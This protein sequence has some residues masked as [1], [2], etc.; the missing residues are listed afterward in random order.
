MF[1]S[2]DSDERR[3]LYR[4]SVE[5]PSNLKHEESWI[6]N[7]RGMLIYRQSFIPTEFKAV[8]CLVHGF[9]DHS[10]NLYMDLSIM[11]A[12]AGYAVV[13]IDFE[14]H[15][16]SDGLHCFIPSLKFLAD[17]L[18]QYLKCVSNQ[19][20][21]RGKKLFLYGESMGGATT[22]FTSVRPDV[23]AISG[24]ILVAPMIKI[25]DKMKPPQ[26]VIDFLIWLSKY[27]PTSPIAPVPD[28]LDKCFKRREI[29]LR[30]RSDPLAYKKKPRLQSSVAMLNATIELGSRMEDLH[31]PTLILHGGADEVTDPEVSI[32]VW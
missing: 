28:I 29:L 10:G 13:S 27:L 7:K 2:D 8:V 24:L 26:V 14:G 1:N 9:G 25:S 6:P 23:P 5:I 21:F 31:H 30:A 15:G 17:D 18:T 3:K 11:L 16:R 20:I 12:K 4:R 32:I 22:F 19:E